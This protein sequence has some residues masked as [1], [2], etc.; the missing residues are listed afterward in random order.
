MLHL[1]F[2]S[3]FSEDTVTL[4]CSNQIPTISNFQADQTVIC[5]LI[6]WELPVVR[7]T[8]DSFAQELFH[9]SVMQPGFQ[10]H[11]L[12]NLCLPVG[13]LTENQTCP[14]PVS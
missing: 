8:S 7:F 11:V 5:L 12:S 10:Q 1:S 4:K 9:R 6:Q 3:C 14:K 13:V 2:R